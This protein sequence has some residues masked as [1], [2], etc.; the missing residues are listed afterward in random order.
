M[1]THQ[2]FCKLRD[3]DVDSVHTR[4]AVSFEIKRLFQYRPSCLLV[5]RCAGL[6]SSLYVGRHMLM[7]IHNNQTVSLK[8]DSVHTRFLLVERLRS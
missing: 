6:F 2:A 7:M 4:L 8:A 5:E 3:E 1:S